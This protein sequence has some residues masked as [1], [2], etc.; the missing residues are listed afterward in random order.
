[1][2]TSC[3][4]QIDRWEQ[5]AESKGDVLSAPQRPFSNRYLDPTHPASNGGLLGLLS[6]GKLTPNMEKQKESMRSA[7]AAQ[8]QAIRDQ[9]SLQ[10]A[11]L[12]QVLQGMGLTPEQQRDYVKQYEQAYEMQLQQFQQQSELLEHGQRR[13]NRV[14][15][16]GYKYY[17]GKIWASD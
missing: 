16:S 4:S 17:H 3:C 12:N 10:M 2:T 14:C 15:Y 11:N 6:G 9:Q 13:I 7:M 1:M 5:A 8:E